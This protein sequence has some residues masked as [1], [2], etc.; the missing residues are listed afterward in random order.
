MLVEPS[1]FRLVPPGTE[2]GASKALV[3]GGDG[4]EGAGELL[5]TIGGFDCGER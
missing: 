1:I 3:E 5:E 2:V 4:R